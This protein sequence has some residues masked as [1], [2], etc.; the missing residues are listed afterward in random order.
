MPW[1]RMLTYIT[2]SVDEELLWRIK[3]LLRV[4]PSR[5]IKQLSR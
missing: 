2:G 1:K 3:Y 4:D 5:F